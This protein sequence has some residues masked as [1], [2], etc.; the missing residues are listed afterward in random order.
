MVDL[1][2][3]MLDPFQPWERVRYPRDIGFALTINLAQLVFVVLIVQAA[4]R[5]IDRVF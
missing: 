5:P 4:L 3:Q 1:L 2:R